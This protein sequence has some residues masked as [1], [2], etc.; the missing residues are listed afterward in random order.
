[1]GSGV[2]LWQVGERKMVKGWQTAGV[3]VAA[4]SPNGSLVAFGTTGG[5]IQ[6]WEYGVVE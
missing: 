3:T 4:F 1:V 5:E 2:I 6:V